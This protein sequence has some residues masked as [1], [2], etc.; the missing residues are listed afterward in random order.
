MRFIAYA[1]LA[2][3][4]FVSSPADARLRQDAKVRYETRE[5]QSKWYT[6]EVNFL[7]G[8]EL[9]DATSSLRY[10]MFKNYAVIFWRENEAT[11][12]EIAGFNFCSG[13]FSQTCLP[14][15]GRMNGEDAD[16]T[17]WEVCTGIIC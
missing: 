15:L 2:V 9:S 8:Q 10:S 6:V 4:A 13:E 5:G 14:I 16:G 12:I 1:A 3:V 7:T 17:K 11:V